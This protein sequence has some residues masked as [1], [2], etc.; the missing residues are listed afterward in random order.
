M[1]V[2]AEEA[3]TLAAR[4]AGILEV[5]IVNGAIVPGTELDER[6]LAERFEVSRTPV[7]EALRKLAAEGLVDLPPRRRAVVKALDP[8]RL[9]QMFE[10]LASLEALAAEC[11]ARRMTPEQ[12][13]RLEAQHI[14]IGHAVNDR[15]GEDYDALNHDF[16]RQIYD[17]A[18]NAY[19][20]EHVDS[21]RQRLAPYRRWLLR[22][23]NRMR[24]S[25]HEHGLI[26]AAIRDGDSA[27]ARVE[28]LAHVRDNERIADIILTKPQS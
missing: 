25:H 2:E 19:L 22:K 11:A 27:R 6:G 13:Q 5:E 8:T 10:V 26:L 23:L 15:G 1:M 16:H 24:Q 20:Q 17:G 21:L 14:A 4:L 18:A 28:M 3:Q 7:R 12:V 9:V